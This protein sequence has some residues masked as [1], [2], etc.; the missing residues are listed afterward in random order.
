MLLL[1]SALALTAAAISASSTAP[2]ADKRRFVP[3]LPD[4]PRLDLYKRDGNTEA[5]TQWNRSVLYSAPVSIGTPPQTFDLR[6]D[7]GTSITYVYDAACN[8]AQCNGR[9]KFSG[10]SSSSYQVANNNTAVVDS[11]GGSATGVWGVDTV[12]V[13]GSVSPSGLF[14]KYGGAATSARRTHS[15]TPRP[16]PVRT[17]DASDV[18]A[19][20]KASGVLGLSRGPGALLD[21]LASKWTDKQF[22]FY[23]SQLPGDTWVSW[24]KSDPANS[25]VESAPGGGLTLGGV[26]SSKYSGDIS[27]APV[28]GDA[29]WTIQLSALSANMSQVALGNDT[30]AVVD[31]GS[32]GV[33]GPS[34][35]V[36][37]LYSAIPGARRLDVGLR[38]D[39]AV[40][41]FPCGADLSVSF[42]IAG[43]EF[44]MLG[45]S[46]VENIVTVGSETL[47]IGSIVG[48]L[49][50][51][52]DAAK[53]TLG[54]MFLRN[55]YTAFRLDPPAV[56]F[57]DLADDI[58]PPR[59]PL[60]YTMLP[61][62]ASL[63]G[64]ASVTDALSTAR[65][66]PTATAAS[67]PSRASLKW[68]RDGVTVAI[69]L[70][71]WALILVFAPSVSPIL[72]VN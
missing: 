3:D 44:P 6:I 31:T 72:V 69:V 71:T 46:L 34:A 45:D 50:N 54:S 10:A 15:L 38:T 11:V 20:S 27:Y 4:L 66:A 51:T 16:P 21:T 36:D 22:G 64:N 42:W 47:C 43:R 28:S 58:R 32:S 40:Y 52:G 9:A 30:S 65:P 2:P 39:V 57:A 18:N 41:A 26:D 29:G 14:C 23:L 67:K 5:L 70:A 53:W 8:A 33:Y 7:T 19:D 55:V 59:T 1:F 25:N 24:L 12:S 63:T 49:R 35:I 37:R 13:G 48:L 56:G 60:P 17:S 61:L 68:S 62:V